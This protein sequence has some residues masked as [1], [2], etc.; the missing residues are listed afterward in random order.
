MTKFTCKDC[1]IEYNSY[2][3]LQCHNSK[4]H[5]IPGVQT[6]VNFYFNGEWPLCK[7]GCSEKLNFQGGKFGEYIRGHKA[8]VSRGF[9]TKEGLEKASSTRKEQFASGDRVQWN[10]GKKYNEVQLA[11]IQESA[12]NPERRRKIAEKLSGKKKSP[13]H[14]AK[15]KADRL[16]YWSNQD[17]RDAQ[18]IRRSNYMKAHLI[19]TESKLEKEFKKILD[20]LDIKYEFQYTVCGY[21]YDFY[22]PSKNTLIEV[23]GNWWHCNAALGIYPIHESQKHTVEHDLVKNKNA[24]ENGYQLL[25]FWEQD[26]TAN[27]LQVVQTLIENFQ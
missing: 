6:Y 17:N 14:I 25:R 12:K 11:S 5:K 18:R 16:E 20:M 10:K 27:R 24:K 3:G 1:N 22:I 21:N 23:D 2:K 15:I 9:Y 26:I 13:E 19:K 8:R 4:T 7:C